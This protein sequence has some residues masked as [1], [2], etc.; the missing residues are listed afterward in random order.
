MYNVDASGVLVLMCLCGADVEWSEIG[1]YVNV[2]L[3]MSVWRWLL[4]WLT[5][6]NCWPFCLCF[7][8]WK[9]PEMQI[10]R[11]SSSAFTCCM[12]STW[13]LIWI[14]V[15]FR[16]GASDRCNCLL[17]EFLSTR[18]TISNWDSL[19]LRSIKWVTSC[20]RTVGLDKALF[21]LPLHTCGT[22]SC[23]C[24]PVFCWCSLLVF[25]S[26]LISSSGLAEP[27]TATWRFWEYRV[28]PFLMLLWELLALTPGTVK[29]T[30]AFSFMLWPFVPEYRMSFLSCAPIAEAFFIQIAQRFIIIHSC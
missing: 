6:A 26:I 29:Y 30:G 9:R 11:C 25:L 10:I 8:Q 1:F 21:S 24:K 20:T 14:S 7:V 23:F 4:T 12:L 27:W 16:V 3:W 5:S 13:R 15:C 28:L 19:W 2:Y 22:R 18:M 17:P